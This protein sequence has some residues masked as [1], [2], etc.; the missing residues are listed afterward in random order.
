MNFAT[1]SPDDP[2]V[3]QVAVVE[4]HSRL[5]SQSESIGAHG[6][7]PSGSMTI[8]SWLPVRPLGR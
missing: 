8:T 5:G 7:P 6:Q 1:H 2:Y 4:D 3:K